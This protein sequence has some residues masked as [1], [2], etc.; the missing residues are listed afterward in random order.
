MTLRVF[1]AGRAQTTVITAEPTGGIS[2]KYFSSWLTGD[3]ASKLEFAPERGSSMAFAEAWGPWFELSEHTADVLNSTPAEL[4]RACVQKYAGKAPGPGSGD[5]ET[6]GVWLFDALVSQERLQQLAAVAADVCGGSSQV[7]YRSCAAAIAAPGGGNVLTVDI[8]PG[9]TEFGLV[10][11]GDTDPV[12]KLAHIDPYIGLSSFA[13]DIEDWAARE[14]PPADAF[15]S[16]SEQMQQEYR[17]QVVSDLIQNASFLEDREAVQYGNIRRMTGWDV[18]FERITRED[19]R[20]VWSKKLSWFKATL[21]MFIETAKR[22][23]AAPEHVV[24]SD[25]FGV[26][27]AMEELMNAVLGQADLDHAPIKGMHRRTGDEKPMQLTGAAKAVE[28]E[29]CL[30]ERACP[31]YARLG[32]GQRVYIGTRADVRSASRGFTFSFEPGDRP[33]MALDLYAGIFLH[34]GLNT[35]CGGGEFNVPDDTKGPYQVAF[36]TRPD[37]K[38]R[39]GFVPAEVVYQYACGDNN[40]QLAWETFDCPICLRDEQS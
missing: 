30:A 19:F 39:D 29:V 1:S 23:N 22:R 5:E 8:R 35:H 2:E 36:Q 40:D 3:L 26:P 7:G 15:Y 27:W 38:N 25:P 14:C 32:A 20:R 13:E 21:Q 10:R 9:A 33:V 28:N 37:T 4:L 17:A 6:T 18:F 34:D 31:V 24:F 12:L 16:L 11:V